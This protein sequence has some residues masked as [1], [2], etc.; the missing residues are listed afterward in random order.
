MT[1]TKNL[2]RELVETIVVEVLGGY[3]EFKEYYEWAKVCHMN[4]RYICTD[5][6]TGHSVYEKGDG[7][8]I[9]I[10]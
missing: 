8:F 9:L 3:E 5:F 1:K 2:G 6:E 4:L 7:T 10:I